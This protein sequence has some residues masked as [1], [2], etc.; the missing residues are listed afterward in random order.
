MTENGLIAV[1]PERSSVMC[2]SCAGTSEQA[3]SE[4]EQMTRCSTNYVSDL[5]LRKYNY[6]PV[7]TGY[8]GK[9]TYTT[10]NT[11]PDIFLVFKLKLSHFL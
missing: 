3:C 9:L 4:V 6:R 10:Q 7:A 11:Y 1:C 2:S 5:S 8:I